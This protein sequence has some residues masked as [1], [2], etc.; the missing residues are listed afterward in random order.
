MS[1]HS[2]VTRRAMLAFAAGTLAASVPLPAV[3]MTKRSARKLVERV[4]ADINTVID[5]GK[6]EEDMLA[7]F[8]Q[9]F[10]DYADVNTIARYA[11]GVE[12]RSATASQ[13]KAFTAA[14]QKYMAGKYGRRFREFI[15]GRVE[16][17]G[18]REVKSF[19]E[20]TTIAHLQGV[21]PFE[22]AFLVSDRSGEEKFF[23]MFIE[24]LS[25]LLSERTEIG[26]MLD[27]RGGDL[28][29]MIKDLQKLG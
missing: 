5:S 10:V 18:V 3:A 1:D 24:G 22:V 19:F 16:V 2:Y 21:A 12:A 6:S 25:M 23:N 20:V 11:L 7:D 26:A 17:T 15:G 9:I 8:E 4:V 13:L 27:K 29:R 28:D 14:F